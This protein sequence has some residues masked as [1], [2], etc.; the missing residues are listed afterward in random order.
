MVRHETVEQVHVVLANRAEVEE[1]INGRVLQGQLSE[2]CQEL[3]GWRESWMGRR[4]ARLLDL[5]G[6]R[7]RGSQTVRAEI[8]ADVGRVRGVVIR[9]PR[10]Q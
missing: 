10:D 3:V 2:T 4:T 1:F 5:V 9:L 7:T 6:L 8:L